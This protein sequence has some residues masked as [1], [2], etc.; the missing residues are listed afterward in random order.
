MG[1][2]FAGSARVVSRAEDQVLIGIVSSELYV[3][4]ELLVSSRTG[5]R[6]LGDMNVVQ[7]WLLVSMTVQSGTVLC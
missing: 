6:S 5:N 4:H 3:D 1:Y 7:Y 2:S